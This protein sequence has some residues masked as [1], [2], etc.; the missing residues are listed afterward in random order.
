[1]EKA[2]QEIS[3]VAPRCRKRPLTQIF[4]VETPNSWKRKAAHRL[5]SPESTAGEKP[6]PLL[7][8]RQT[9]LLGQ[10]G[11]RT[12]AR[13]VHGPVDSQRLFARKWASEESGDPQVAGFY[14]IGIGSRKTLGEPDLRFKSFAEIC[15]RGRNTHEVIKFAYGGRRNNRLILDGMESCARRRRF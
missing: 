4:G 13:V 15:E 3:N 14:S 10:R 12:A 1:M 5:T 2:T 7:P 6:N 11:L 8:R 9:I